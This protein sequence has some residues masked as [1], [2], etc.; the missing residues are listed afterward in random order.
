MEDL[1]V[2]VIIEYGQLV[3][4]IIVGSVLRCVERGYMESRFKKRLDEM[5]FRK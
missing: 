5:K 1:I 4:A 2:K 3:G